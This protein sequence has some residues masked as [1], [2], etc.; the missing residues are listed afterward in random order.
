[1][2]CLQEY[3][4]LV[5]PCLRNVQFHLDKRPLKIHLLR[6]WSWWRTSIL[7]FSHFWA[8][9]TGQGHGA[10]RVSKEVRRSFSQPQALPWG[11]LSAPRTDGICNPSDM[12]WVCPEF[13]PSL[14]CPEHFQR[15]PPRHLNWLLS[16]ELVA[17]HHGP[18]KSQSS[19]LWNVKWGQPPCRNIGF[20]QLV[21]AI[22]MVRDQSNCNSKIPYDWFWKIRQNLT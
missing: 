10:N 14:S 5:F 16:E 4:V 12:F 2:C 15:E 13:P 6:Q 20:H 21:S 1:M 18:P 3:M 8:T 22:C 19:S 7:P 17:R 9:Y 11:S